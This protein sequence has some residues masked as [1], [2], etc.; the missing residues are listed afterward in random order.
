M[1][2]EVDRSRILY[3]SLDFDINP[4]QFPIS[5]PWVHNPKSLPRTTL[6]DYA[7][8]ADTWPLRWR[9]TNPTVRKLGLLEPVWNMHFSC[10][11]I[12]P[13]HFLFISHHVV[14][15]LG[16]CEPEWS[17][18]MSYLHINLL[19]DQV[20]WLLVR[21]ITHIRQVLLKVFLYLFHTIILMNNKIDKTSN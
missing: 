7:V 16:M 14:W 11:D 8:E 18:Y 20:P 3:F 1:W 19:M 12:L 4:C 15:K 21:C 9:R 13:I 10:F 5:I 2:S 17:I 6:S